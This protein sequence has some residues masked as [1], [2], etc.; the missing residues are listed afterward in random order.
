MKKTVIA[1]DFDDIVADFN[2][3]FVPYHNKIYGTNLQYEDI[4]AHEMELVYGE[5]ISTMMDRIS[6]FYHSHEHAAINPVKGAVT[7][8]QDLSNMATLHIVTSRPSEFQE[9]TL[10]W[11]DNILP[12][13]FSEV[14]FTNGFAPKPGTV[15]RKKSQVCE[16][17]GAAVLIEDALVNVT[18]VLN[19]GI[20]VLMLDRPWNQSHTPA[21]ATRVWHWEEITTWVATHLNEKQRNQE[22]L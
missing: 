12:N 1:I 3:S 7:A 11:I 19:A 20:P 10:Q 21:G 14:H 16:E 4:F 13:T 2:R 5:T 6:V 22:K 18:D 17:I 9:G 15:R 8:L